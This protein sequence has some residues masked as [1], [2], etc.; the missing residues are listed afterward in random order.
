MHKT[1]SRS[2]RRTCRDSISTKEIFISPKKRTRTDADPNSNLN[3]DFN[4]E[5]NPIE[6]SLSESKRKCDILFL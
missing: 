2:K 3:V 4:S 5:H 1:I 6:S